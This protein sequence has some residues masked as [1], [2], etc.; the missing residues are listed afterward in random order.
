MIFRSLTEA[1]RRLDAE[2]E[3]I[4]RLHYPPNSEP[5]EISEWISGAY[6]RTKTGEDSEK[7]LKQIEKHVRE[8]QSIYE[9]IENECQDVELSIQLGLIA[10]YLRLLFPFSK[11]LASLV[12][13]GK[14]TTKEIHGY[15]NIWY[16][17]LEL[18]E[19]EII[20]EKEHFASRYL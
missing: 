7:E 15:G 5:G 20:A 8:A 1:L 17:H 3:I 2:I 19:D 6:N 13:K 9:K 10:S 16:D 4:R 14:D 18:L 11:F 12:K